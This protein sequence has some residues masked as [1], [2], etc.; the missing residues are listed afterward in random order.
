MTPADLA[1]ANAISFEAKKDSLRQMQSGD[2][3]ISFTVQGVDMDDRITRAA[4]GTRFVAVLVEINDQ[5]L[6][7]TLAAKE[8]PKPVSPATPQPDKLDKPLLVEAKRTWNEFQPSQ[9]AGIRSHD[10]RFAQFLEEEY[11]GYWKSEAQDAA[12]CIR[13]ICDVNSRAVLGMDHSKRVLWNH[14]DKHFQAWEA[15]IRMNA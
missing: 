9:Q 6:P 12:Q 5:E 3:K 13:A 15:K 2:W 4:M 8:N 10:V 1:R 11:P 7:V 14:L